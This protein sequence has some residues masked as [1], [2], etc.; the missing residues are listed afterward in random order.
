MGGMRSVFYAILMCSRRDLMAFQP[1]LTELNLP[2][3]VCRYIDDDIAYLAVVYQD[4]KQLRKATEPAMHIPSEDT[5]YLHP[6]VL[7]L[8]P[9]GTQRF[10]ELTVTAVCTVGDRI[11]IS[12]YNKVDQ[13]WK[14]DESCI[15][16]RLPN[17]YRNFNEKAVFGPSIRCHFN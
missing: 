16:M 2:S 8:E 15:Q 5:G 3:A 10:L 13:D 7:N 1:R 4:N 9:E 6:L 14:Q 17:P 12:F 11:V